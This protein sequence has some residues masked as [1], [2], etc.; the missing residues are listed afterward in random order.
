MRTINHMTNELGLVET[1]SATRWDM[2]T[3]NIPNG[4]SLEIFRGGR[5]LAS[6]TSQNMERRWDFGVLMMGDTI[7]KVNQGYRYKTFQGRLHSSDGFIREYA[8]DLRL[9]VS[10]PTLF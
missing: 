10:N 5:H 3:L 2:I 6:F 7:L 1:I 8:I 9:H 4:F